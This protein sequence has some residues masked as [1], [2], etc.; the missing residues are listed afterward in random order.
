M[1]GR[2]QGRSRRPR[3]LGRRGR[4]RL[5]LQQLPAERGRR[6]GVAHGRGRQR[7]AGA[8][9][10]NADARVDQQPAQLRA[11]PAG[12]TRTGNALGAALSST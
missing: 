7:C 6:I 12:A 4:R 9:G 1:A 5:L 11:G 2:R 8:G 10:G 3:L